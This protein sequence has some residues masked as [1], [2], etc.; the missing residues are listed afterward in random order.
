[1]VDVDTF[2]TA[3]Y[4]VVDT[5]CQTR[6]PAHRRGPAAAL[7]RSEGV[8]LALFS[9]WAHF[10]SERAFY[11]YAQCHLRPAFPTLP[12]CSQFSRQVRAQQPHVVAFALYLA[13]RLGAATAAYEALDGTP[14][15]VR[16]AHRRGA[17]W[18]AGQATIGW[19]SALGWYEGFNLLAAVAPDGVLTG[20][21]LGAA[22]TKD[23]PLAET[24]FAARAG[25]LPGLISVGDPAAGPYVV[26][27][28]FEGDQH[29]RHWAQ[30]Y[31]AQV[32][33][34]PKR[35]ARRSWPPAWHRWL[36]R[37]RQM[38]ETVFAHL[39]A[40][41]GLRA[42]RP[43]CLLGLQVRLAATAALHNFCIWLNRHLGRHDLAFADLITW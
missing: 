19:S 30:A 41:F 17:G 27:K 1:M 28:G 12:A 37:R 13:Q 43:H 34:P 25:L 3:L 18:L 42:E 31:G 40:T 11:R 35:G 29:H 38:V 9:Q 4:V 5:F 16:N 10:P 39:H 8:P 6:P 33:C 26:D 14:V 24:F 7:D 22:S 2:L 32:L 21:G 20:Y 36:A 23:Q 15:P